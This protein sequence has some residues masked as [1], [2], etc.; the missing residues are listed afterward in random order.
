MGFGFVRKKATTCQFH[1]T[2]VVVSCGH[3]LKELFL[4]QK[5]KS[6]QWCSDL[7]QPFHF[8]FE[9]SEAE[10]LIH[11][12]RLKFWRELEFV[13]PVSSL[14]LC[15]E[16]KILSALLFRRVMIHSLSVFCFLMHGSLLLGT[17]S[18]DFSWNKHQNDELVPLTGQCL[19]RRSC[20]RQCH[21]AKWNL[22]QC[23][24]ALR[25]FYSL[26]EGS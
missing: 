18:R 19:I 25:T 14:V 3:F 7:S 4:G 13:I 1:L 2:E 9:P 11:P 6:F 21:W 15:V 26:L 8:A 12:D 16:R 22:E 17:G 20:S 24:V 23:Q 5:N 10:M